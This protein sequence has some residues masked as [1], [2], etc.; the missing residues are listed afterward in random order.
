LRER[1]SLDADFVIFFL[2]LPDCFL[3]LCFFDSFADC[4]ILVST[5]LGDFL[6]RFF[7]RKK[8]EIHAEPS[9]THLIVPREKK[10]PNNDVSRQYFHPKKTRPNPY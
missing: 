9:L 8:E 6:T 1:K 2:Y 5:G 4:S 10:Q 7:A 3:Y